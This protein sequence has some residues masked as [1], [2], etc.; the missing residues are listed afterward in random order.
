MISRTRSESLS[1]SN[2]RS[3]SLISLS[4][5]SESYSSNEEEDEVAEII[6]NLEDK[7]QKQNWRKEIQEFKIEQNQIDE[8]LNLFTKSLQ[9]ENSPSFSEKPKFTKESIFGNQIKKQSI[10][11]PKTPR[12]TSK[13][14]KS[15]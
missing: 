5:S 15:K 8:A 7:I 9:I 11:R 1:R 13:K 4:Y 10:S 2:S 12:S 3:R 6:V 14:R